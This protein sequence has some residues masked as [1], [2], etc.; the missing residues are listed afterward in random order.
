M[1]INQYS[2]FVGGGHHIEISAVA[3]GYEEYREGIPILKTVYYFKGMHPYKLLYLVSN[4][5]FLLYLFPNLFLCH[6]YILLYFDSNFFYLETFSAISFPTSIQTFFSSTFS[7]TMHLLLLP[8]QKYCFGPYH[9]ECLF[10]QNSNL[11]VLCH[12]IGDC[13]F[14]GHVFFWAFVKEPK[15]HS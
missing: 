5:L 6:G 9:L 15:V 3:E 10:L 4:C 7:I 8:C 1:Q 2:S 14:S 12:Y 13:G 11:A